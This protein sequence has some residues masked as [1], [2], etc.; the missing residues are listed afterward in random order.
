MPDPPD[1]A[2]L[3]QLKDHLKVYAE[4]GIDGFDP[5]AVR[6]ARRLAA[7]ARGERRSRAPRTQQPAPSTQTSLFAESGPASVPDSSLEEVRD[8]LGDCQRCKLCQDRTHIVFGA[9]NPRARLVFVGEGPGVEEDRQGLPFVGRAG[10]LLTRMI[11][12]IQMRRDEV[13]IC[14]VVKCRPPKNRTP[15][16]D[17]IAACS[18]FLLR[19]LAVL[20]PEVICCLGLTAAQ[21][22]LQVRTPIGRLRGKIHSFSGARLVATYH[23]AYLLR[24]PAAK[25][26]VWEDLKKIRSLLSSS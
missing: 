21:T 5:E 12:A 7:A 13:Y 19:Q 18:P 22:L 15:Q 24:N 20:Q 4:S 17:E 8:D 25:R 6:G 14:N 23:P 10:Q 26:E 9:G 3:E 11:E 2:L 1:P 16:E